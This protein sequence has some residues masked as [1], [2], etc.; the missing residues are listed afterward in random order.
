MIVITNYTSTGSATGIRVPE[1]VESRAPADE[2]ATVPSTDTGKSCYIILFS[3][4]CCIAESNILAVHCKSA[5]MDTRETFEEPNACNAPLHPDVYATSVLHTQVNITWNQ[6]ERQSAAR[7]NSLDEQLY[8]LEN[9]RANL[10][11]DRCIH[12][13]LLPIN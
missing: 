9:K 4:L 8:R 11:N 5:A 7:D 2:P 10:F 3:P 12:T 13:F 6:S 1:T